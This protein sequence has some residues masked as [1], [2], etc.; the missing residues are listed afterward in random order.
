MDNHYHLLLQ[1]PAANLAEIMDHING[2]FT[3][4]FNVKRPRCGH[5]FQERYKAILVDIERYWRLFWGRAIR[6]L[7]CGQAGHWDMKK[8]SKAKKESTRWK[9][10]FNHE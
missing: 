2:A 1:T 8:G 10:V 3:T 4:Y 5:L 6:R 9:N 7:P